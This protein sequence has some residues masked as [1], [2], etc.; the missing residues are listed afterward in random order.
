MLQFN[1]YFR[2]KAEDIVEMDIFSD[3]RA[4]YPELL[5]AP[6]EIIQLEI[7]K[8]GAFNYSNSSFSNLT[9]EDVIALLTEEIL[10]I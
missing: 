5:V 1:P 3:L 8:K 9:L 6:S 10:F 4:Q 2:Q 7:D